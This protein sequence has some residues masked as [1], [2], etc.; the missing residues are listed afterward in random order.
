[1]SVYYSK[2]QMEGKSGGLI[3]L[4]RPN[5]LLFLIILLGMME[6]WVAEPILAQYQLTP[7]LTWWQLL[8]L[9]AGVVLI[10][11]G[12]FV[13]NDYFDVKIDAINRPDELIVSRDVPKE[14]AMILFKALTAAG[15]T[16]GLAVSIVLKSVLLG[17]IFVIVPGMLWFYSSSYKRMFLVG[18]LVVALL[19]ALTPLVIAFANGAALSLRY[20]AETFGSI[21][22]ANEMIVWMGGFAVFFF[23]CMWIHEVVKN[24]Q[25]VE[26]DREL[27][28]HTFPVKYGETA[29]KVF[30]TVLLAITC[31]VLSFF[32]FVL[33]P[34][35]FCWGNFVSRFYLLLMIALIC[36]LVLLWSGKL[37][38]DYRNA[39]V[40]MKFI[41]FMGT[42]YAIC[43][44]KIIEASWAG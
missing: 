32:N 43:V 14:E 1:M 16:C 42:M 37:P 34:M 7:Q 44:P 21:Y 12:G 11:A 6:K 29:S 10:A 23:L 4:M 38:T 15:I 5:T 28:C 36:E 17:S 20:G 9:I 24:M 22:V 39:K 25:N 18:N 8:L 40:L 35:A 41:L 26:G 33:L 19:V 27:E 2:F 13:A 3:R 31:I 30:A